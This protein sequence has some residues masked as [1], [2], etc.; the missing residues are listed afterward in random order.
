M[1]TAKV[2]TNGGSQAVRLPKTCRFAADE[3]FVNRIGNVVILFPKEERWQSLLSSLD[4]FTDD[5]LSED[6]ADLP[7]AEREVII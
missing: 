4:L 2:F 3:V 5:F 7:L 6:I 1:D